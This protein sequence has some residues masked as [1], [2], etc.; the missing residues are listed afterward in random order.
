MKSKFLN[1]SSR[2]YIRQKDSQNTLPS[3]ERTGY[4]NELRAKYE[5]FSENDR[6]IVFQTGS[7]VLAPYMVPK[8]IADL[9]SFEEGTLTLTAS[10]LS[11]NVYLDRAVENDP[12]FPFKEGENTAAYNREQEGDGISESVYPGFSSPE[13]QKSA[14]VIDITSKQSA[15]VFKLNNLESA[16]DPSGSFL[17]QRGSGFMYYSSELRKWVDVGVRDPA[18]NSLKTYNPTFLLDETNAA[19]NKFVISNGQNSFMCQFSSSPYS[20]TAEGPLYVPDTKALRAR[21]YD[22]I[23]EPTSFFGA[24]GAARYHA[25]EANTIKLS[26]YISSPFVVDRISVKIPVTAHRAQTPGTGSATADNGYGR[27]ID[28]YVF[29]VYLQ[30]R[31]GFT[32]DSKQDVSSSI[33]YLIGRQSFCFYNEPTLD[34]I[35]LGLTPLH[36]YGQSGSFF[37]LSNEAT[38]AGT[39]VTQKIDANIDITFR[40]K[41]FNSTFGALSKLPGAAFISAT[42][43]NITGSVFIQNFWKGGQLADGRLGLISLSNNTNNLNVRSGSIPTTQE[44]LQI[45]P[46]PRALVTS[47]FDCPGSFISSGSGIAELGIEYKNVTDGVF[48]KETP[49]V[50]F[51]EDE[52]VFG[53]ESGINA[54]MLSPERLY[55]G[56]DNDVLLCTGSYLTINAGDAKVILYGSTV[57]ENK[58]R[59]PVLNQYLGSDAVHEDIHEDGPYDQFD[60]YVPEVLT[61]SYIDNICTGPLLNRRRVGSNVL[62]GGWV[63]GSFQR[64]VRLINT[65]TLYYDTLTPVVSEISGGLANTTDQPVTTVEKANGIQEPQILKVIEDTNDFAFNNDRTGNVL[66]KRS[67]T[68]E[69]STSRSKRVKS[70]ILRLYSSMPS[71]LDQSAGSKAKAIVYYN[72]K[73]LD[74]GTGDGKLYDGAASLR[75]GLLSIRLIGP[76]SVFRRDRF[77]QFRDML[78]QSRDSKLL[79]NKKGKDSIGQSVVVATFVSASSDIA[80]DGIYTQCS[81]LSFECTSSLPFTDAI[82][83]NRGDD[84]PATKAKSGPNNLIFGVTGSFGMQ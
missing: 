77:G 80:T 9:S 18:T 5:P 11:R 8:T 37:M 46:S 47:F 14:I 36:E 28:N 24:P 43:K 2:V 74:I 81:N 42:S 59:L 45:N 13:Y 64:N 79:T 75:Y 6:T 67:F 29:F 15:D 23:G 35:E 52:L 10:M 48:S 51:P 53:I 20:M 60:I 38:L 26:S 62:D 61:G 19:A 44:G 58:E 21:G 65:Q 12:V 31:L 22:R 66:L 55:R 33:R 7:A 71:L 41:T 34:E 84:V 57:S 72:G 27:D 54:N 68:F 50:L 3:I 69:N 56:I 78:E 25:S 70:F 63:T 16:R 83:R 39:T 30:N 73:N 82:A 17:G 1:V 49:V 4:Q 40:P 76:S 32:K